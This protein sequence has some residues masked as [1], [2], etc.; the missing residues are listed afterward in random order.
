MID[1][2][3]ECFRNA[4]PDCGK[5]ALRNMMKLENSTDPPDINLAYFPRMMDFL[6]DIQKELKTIERNRQ[7]FVTK[8]D[9]S[10]EQKVKEKI[11]S[12]FEK[13]NSVSTRSENLFKLALKGLEEK[14]IELNDPHNLDSVLRIPSV[15]ISILQSKF[16]GLMVEFNRIQVNVQRDYKAKLKRQIKLLDRDI[17][18]DDADQLINDPDK[19]Q[20]FFMEKMYG[21][22]PGLQNAMSDIDEKL[23]EIKELKRNM[24]KLLTLMKNLH[25]LVSQQTEVLVS[26]EGSVDNIKAHVTSTNLELTSGRGYMQSA[27][28]V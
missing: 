19:M 7:D 24:K 22:T 1:D 14:R 23:A 18:E 4:N 27:K 5:S 28:S 20:Q 11:A 6:N 17:N 9:I 10:V 15:L 8:N 16:M 2:L 12:S 26:I 13:V 21:A 3:Y 25:R